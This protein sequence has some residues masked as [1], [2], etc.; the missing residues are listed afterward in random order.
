MGKRKQELG[1]VVM[2]GAQRQ[3]EG[4]ESDEVCPAP[5]VQRMLNSFSQIAG[6]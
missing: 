1:D 3:D 4:D 5:K 2:D 6:H